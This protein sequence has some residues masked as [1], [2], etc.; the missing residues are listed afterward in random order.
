MEKTSPTTTYCYGNKVAIVL[1]I[2]EKLLAIMIEDEVIA[3]SF[4]EFFEV[5]WKNAYH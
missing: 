4:K 3:N 1:W 5:L 2:K